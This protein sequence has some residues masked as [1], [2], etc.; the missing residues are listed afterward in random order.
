MIQVPCI[1]WH[2]VGLYL[3]SSC[4]ASDWVLVFRHLQIYFVVSLVI[5]VNIC[6]NGFFVIWY[7][8]ISPESVDNTSMF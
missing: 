2:Q 8:K 4:M 3:V 6:F 7:L 1:D 5:F